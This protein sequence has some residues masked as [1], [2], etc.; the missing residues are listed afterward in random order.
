MSTFQ[1]QRT[2]RLKGATEATREFMRLGLD[3]GRAVD[4]FGVIESKRVWLLFEPLDHLFGFFQREQRGAGIVLHSG[5]PLSVQRF[6]A[7]HEYAHYAL[8]HELSQDSHQELFGAAGL[9]LQELEAQAFA[10]EFLMPLPLVNRALDRLALPR[11]PRILTPIEAYQLSLEM[12]SS[13]RATITQLRQLNKIPAA[14]VEQLQA[15]EPI[16]IKTEL[17]D[18][19]RPENARAD[20]WDVNEIRRARNLRLRVDDE[21]H[22]RLPEI[23]TSG[24]RWDVDV[25]GAALRPVLD[26]LETD[27]HAQERL[28][29]ALRRHLWWR[30]IEPG[31][32]TMS[33]RLVRQ[34]QDS[35]AALDG[36]ELELTVQ[37]PR[38]GLES[39]TGI[40]LPQR[41]ALVAE[42]A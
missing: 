22:V 16:Q 14:L 25:G 2:A 17:G 20:V 4:V 34:W 39:T 32:A 3:A 31:S 7:A 18:G 42:A 21:L 40:S 23:P 33:L 36:L 38:T 5:H 28:G 19:R 35:G 6:T 15:W 9:P 24:Y 8:G 13:Y 30:A 27:L 26:E 11:E 12:G 1:E 41:R 29:S 10:A 37:M